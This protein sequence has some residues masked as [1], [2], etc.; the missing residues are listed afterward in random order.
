[1]KLSELFSEENVV[2]DLPAGSK[3]DVLKSIIRDLD[4]K[5]Y[6]AQHIDQCPPLCMITDC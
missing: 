5:G 6:I 2:T 3:G 1:M 4:G